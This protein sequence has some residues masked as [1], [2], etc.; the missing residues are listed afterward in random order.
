M[1]EGKKG[2]AGSSI[3]YTIF[4]LHRSYIM[5]Y[6]Q[7]GSSLM[8]RKSSSRNH[9]WLAFIIWSRAKVSCFCIG[10]LIGSWHLFHKLTSPSQWP[11]EAWFTDE[12]SLKQKENIKKYEFK[13]LRS[14]YNFT[15]SFKTAPGWIEWDLRLKILRE[16]PNLSNQD[17]C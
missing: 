15:Q 2:S 6:I 16:C 9:F 5:G 8:N 3:L 14:F 4:H 11:H 12:F 17:K 13:I 7:T 10:L 1:K